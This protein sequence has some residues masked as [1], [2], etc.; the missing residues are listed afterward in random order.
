MAAVAESEYQSKVWPS[1]CPPARV[2]ASAVEILRM[3]AR[4][5]ARLAAVLVLL[6]AWALSE[7]VQ[8]VVPLPVPQKSLPAYE[9]KQTDVGNG[10]E[11]LTLVQ[12]REAGREDKAAPLVSVLRDSVR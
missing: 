9:W 1:M 4:L 12:K 7:D 10:A 8:R 11:I 5:F 3:G 2:G 6:S